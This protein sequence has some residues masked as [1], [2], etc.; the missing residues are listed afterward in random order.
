MIGTTHGMDAPGAK[1]IP[2]VFLAGGLLSVLLALALFPWEQAVTHL[3]QDMFGL[4]QPSSLLTY[5]VRFLQSF[6]LFFG[7]AL[8]GTG[9]LNWNSVFGRVLSGDPLERIDDRFIFF[10]AFFFCLPL[11]IFLE[12]FI[13][14]RALYTP[15]EFAYLYQ[16]KLFASG[17]ITGPA[18]ALQ[19]FFPTAFIAESDGRLFSIMPPGYSL[20]LVPW[21]WIGCARLANPFLSCLN[22]LLAYF[23]GRRLYDKPTGLLAAF[24]M[25]LSPF[26]L[27][28]TG[29]YMTHTLSLFLL[30]IAMILYLR[31]ERE[32]LS[33]W[34]VCI[35]LG[36]VLAFIPSVHHFD[37]FFLVPVMF[38][39]AVRFF[40]GPNPVRV[41]IFLVGSLFLGVQIGFTLG[42]N[43]V[44]T[45]SP[46]KIPL[47]IYM[48]NENFLGKPGFGIPPDGAMVGLSSGTEFLAHVVRLASQFVKLNLVLLPLAP[49]F[50]IL[51]VLSGGRS[52]QDILLT[53]CIA[54][55]CFA[56]L[57]YR[58][59]GGFQLGPR[60][61]YLAVAFFY[62]LIVRG[63]IVLDQTS[64][65]RPSG[66]TL[67]KVLSIVFVLVLSC[68]IGLSAGTLRFVKNL[69][70][71]SRFLLDVGR[72][73]EEQGI[74][75]SIVFITTTEK[76]Q[77]RDPE[78]VF[79]LVRNHQDITGS[80]LTARDLGGENAE[81]M[82]YYPEKRA[83]LYE[84]D[85]DLLPRGGPMRWKEIRRED[86]L[87]GD[88]L[89]F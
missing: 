84:V 63:F 49:L 41:R 43:Y 64:S 75:N 27:C 7:L 40:K 46:W 14:Q 35:L 88:T 12:M 31:M 58:P 36:L 13:F 59:G 38:V 47:D 42:H 54:A 45:G 17:H 69:N 57:F 6:F 5:A 44:L 82:D 25:S 83:F 16:A 51:P 86:Y 39:L 74:E 56:Y 68:Q 37:V 73:F 77:A 48:Q 11:Y 24:L 81:L 61:Y 87:S 55:M 71:E 72:L 22:V 33:P 30:L 70:D 67:R 79:L 60:Y 1:R 65:R 85:R 21:E 23:V 18:H 34:W 80:N 29:T 4:D 62:F 10:Y 2:A 19:K 53:A 89:K 52:R 15:D 32:P 28:Y 66:P 76:E 26:F 50:M 9:G 3:F 20:F 78:L 8:L